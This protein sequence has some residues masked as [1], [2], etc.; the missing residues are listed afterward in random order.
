MNLREIREGYGPRSSWIE[1]TG[2]SMEELAEAATVV[3]RDHSTAR[4]CGLAVGR[5]ARLP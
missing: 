3:D 2:P 5:G 4:T 1:A